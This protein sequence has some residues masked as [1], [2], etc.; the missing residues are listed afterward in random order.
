MTEDDTGQLA[1][2]RGKVRK[3]RA[4][5][6]QQ[7]APELPVARVL[8]DVP[9]AHLDRP[10]D[11]LVPERMH[12]TCVPGARV[13]VRFAGQDLDGFVLERV[14]ES[15]HRGRLAPLRRVVSAE[16]V[17]AP[18]IAR[19][20]R[21]VAD[22]YAGTLA[23]VLRLAVPP[24]HA[25][26]ECAA[27]KPAS[28][29]APG[30]DPESAPDSAPESSDKVPSAR[31]ADAVRP[32]PWGAYQTGV[33]FLEALRRGDAPRAVWTAVPGEDWPT[34]LA[35]A[36]AATLDGGRG[37][38]VVVPDQRDVARL[39]AAF[40]EVLGPDR[41][42]VL[43]ADLGPAERYRRFLAARRGSVR[44]VVGTRS[45]AFAPVAD[46]GLVTC[47]DDGDDL[48]AEPRA[49]YP[50][51]REVLLLRA[52]ESGCA[53][54]LGGFAC[55]AEG[56][57][58][59]ATGWA[60]P[61]APE[62]AVVR[63]RGPRVVVAGDNDTDLA[64]DP[65][66]RAVRLPHRAFEQARAALGSGPV[67]VQV[68][69]SGYLPA[70]ACQTCRGP[71]RCVTCSGPLQLGS[72][73]APPSC[74][75]C[76][77]PAVSW[78]CPTCG[79]GRL[80]APVVG[81]GRTAEELGR[82][83]PRV[84][85]R[86]SGGSRVLST[87]GA[88]P[89][90]VVATPGAEPVAEGGYSGALLLDSWLALARADL[91]AGEEALRRWFNAAALVRPARAGGSVVVVGDPGSPAIQALVRWSPQDQADR[92]LAEREAARF[93]PAARLATL[94][95]APDAVRDLAGLVELPPG[96]EVLG[97]VPQAGEDEVV[98]LVLRVRWADGARL[99]AALKA[100]Q[101]V[102]SARKAPGPVRVQVDP[103]VLG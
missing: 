44:C 70:L 41:H 18:E 92:E 21:R 48:H 3:P 90:L 23:D 103:A 82:A 52:H 69:R 14:A 20:A 77:R 34:A 6:P 22:R 38:L 55:T 24:R 102:R 51:V 66:A 35:H 60:R 39:D 75:W 42:V 11:Y 83:F 56:A 45:A 68:P 2:V 99:S 26:V 29:S 12:A 73:G 27:A 43:T 8:V 84:P 101:A 9:L 49:P 46:L 95:G 76:G 47:W 97:P 13:R 94:T 10:F 32:G 36:A 100:A 91:R 28:D 31:P 61:L 98:R 74:G 4:T 50:H 19:L 16:P 80:R 40:G 62:R 78:R 58:L 71:A 17:L 30:S 5:S 33:A 72:A 59:L 1:L 54:L 81:A 96:T 37:V 93:P 15:D 86:T 63:D 85:V 89:A 53:A 79:G 65:A 57:H 87:V 64:R 88:E 25:R 7:P 67:L